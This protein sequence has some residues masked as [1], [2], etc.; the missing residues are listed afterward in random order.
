MTDSYFDFLRKGIKADYAV[1]NEV[2]GEG[3]FAIVKKATHRQTG[4]EVAVKIIFKERIKKNK[5]LLAP[6]LNMH[7]L[8]LRK[9]SASLPA[10][11]SHKLCAQEQTLANEIAIMKRVHHPNCIAF[12]ESAR[13]RFNPHSASAIPIRASARPCDH[14]G[15]VI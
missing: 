2:L 13:P 11:C 5:E 10:L 6:K 12:H 1:S 9:S 3:K 8:M 7:V 15:T 14:C 4:E